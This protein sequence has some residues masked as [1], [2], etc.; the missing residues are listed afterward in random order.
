MTLER[1]AGRVLA[2]LD[3]DGELP[4]WACFR[5]LGQ[6]NLNITVDRLKAARY[7]LNVT[8]INSVVQAALGGTVATAVLELIA[9]SGSRCGLHRSFDH[10]STRSEGS[11]LGLRPGTA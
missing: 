5:V 11:R 4:I 7:G 3:R 6:P 9:N 8:D 1:L 10:N 2:E